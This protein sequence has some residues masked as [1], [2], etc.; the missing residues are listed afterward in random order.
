MLVPTVCFNCEAA[1]GL[2][3]YVD[4]R[5]ARDPEARGQPAPPGQ[6]R[7][8]LRQGP[9]DDQP[10]HDPERILYPLRRKR[11]ARR[12]RVGA[13]E[14]GPRARHLRRADARRR[15]RPG[16]PTTSCYFVG[17][18]GEDGFADRFLETWGC[19]GHNSHT[20][21]CSSGGRAGYGFWCGHRPAVA[22]LR[23]RQV[24]AAVLRAPRV[25][26]LLQPARAA[27]RRGQA[28]AARRSPS[29][30][31]GCRTPPRA[32]T[33]GCRPGRAPRRRCCWRSP[34]CCSR[35]TASTASSCA[36]GSTGAPTCAHRAPDAEP[37]FENFIARAQARVR[38]LHA[39]VRR[40]G[41][42]ACPAATIVE[43]AREIAAAAPAFASHIWR[44]A[45]AGNLHGWQ[46]TRA[47]GC[48]TC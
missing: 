23:Q 2:L 32:R 25:R 17:R 12:R 38:A 36:A 47:C 11:P 10:D 20:N 29:W 4:K 18:P 31:R 21:V 46:I 15:S 16:G 6:P 44:A 22:R 42:P 45:A 24:R 19:D 33:T 30:T 1:C 27:H 14:L 48:S 40:A 34:R 13:R 39:R 28:A 8:Q 7:A 35:R 41:E 26:P 9:R 43:V 5:D 3:A 37:T